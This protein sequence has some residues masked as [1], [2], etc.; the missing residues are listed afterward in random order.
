MRRLRVRFS[1]RALLVLIA[2]VAAALGGY[3][4]GRSRAHVRAQAEVT[5]MAISFGRVYDLSNFVEHEPLHELANEIQQV[6]EPQ[7]WSVVGGPSHIRTLGRDKLLVHTHI[8]AQ[9][10]IQE[11]LQ[12]RAE[13]GAYHS[14]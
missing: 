12:R 10:N 6:V 9:Q 7:T 14:R 4:F 1:V 2:S 5:D 3:N 8:G 13:A 11:Y